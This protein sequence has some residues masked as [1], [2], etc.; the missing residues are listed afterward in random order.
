M[1][2]FT[3]GQTVQV[4]PK[5]GDDFT[6][7]WQGTYIGR[8]GEYYSV[9]DANGDVYDC[10]E[11]QIFHEDEEIP[12]TLM[13]EHQELALL[14]VR[15]LTVEQLRQISGDGQRTLGNLLADLRNSLEFADQTACITEGLSRCLEELRR[16]DVH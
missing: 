11:D 3:E 4:S 9:R 7:V 1:K 14:V 8:H 6:H 12:K 16:I 15:D 2:E 5:P 13:E 10:D